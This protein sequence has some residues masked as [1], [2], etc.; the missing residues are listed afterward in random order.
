MAVRF[1]EL[2]LSIC[3]QLKLSVRLRI[4]IPAVENSV[5]AAAVR[6]GDIIRARNGKT[7]EITNTG[8]RPVASTCWPVHALHLMT[9]LLVFQTLKAD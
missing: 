2:R 3:T 5:S 1:A 8:A 4:L 6:P 7:T 9:V